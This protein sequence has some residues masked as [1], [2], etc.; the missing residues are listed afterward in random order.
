MESTIGATASTCTCVVAPATARAH[1]EIDGLP[2]L[3][4]DI[5]RAILREAGFR[6]CHRVSG[7]GRQRGSGENACIRCVDRAAEAERLVRYRDLRVGNGAAG[8]VPHG[9][10]D[11]AKTGDG[12][13]EHA[14][15]QK[16][17]S[18]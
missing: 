6:D 10:G 3:H 11:C 14:R 2:D 13:A 12:L 16:Q 5:F 8:G 7:S 15:A 1:L 4:L 9:A 17:R 18:E